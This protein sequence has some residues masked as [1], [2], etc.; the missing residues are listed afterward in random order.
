M[1]SPVPKTQ[2]RAVSPPADKKSSAKAK[3]KQPPEI[4]AANFN[5][6]AAIKKLIECL[7]G[8]G[9]DRQVLI[10]NVFNHGENQSRWNLGDPVNAQVVR[11]FSR[12]CADARTLH[13]GE[14]EWF[15][16]QAM[17]RFNHWTPGRSGDA[18]AAEFVRRML[19]PSETEFGLFEAVQA[20]KIPPG[21]DRNKRPINYPLSCLAVLAPEPSPAPMTT[22]TESSRP[23]PVTS[24]V[25]AAV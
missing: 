15:I 3:P 6:A 18:E 13:V 9:D 7:S 25:T 23:V 11:L 17:K 16:V 22:L 8:S 21:E 5:I 20:Q 24:N 19:H 14:V 1:P 4:T 10:Y 12:L 2:V